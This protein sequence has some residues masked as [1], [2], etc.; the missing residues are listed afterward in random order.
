MNGRSVSFLFLYATIYRFHVQ[1]RLTQTNDLQSGDNKLT[2]HFRSVIPGGGDVFVFSAFG[3][4]SDNEHMSRSNNDN[5]SFISGYGVASARQ[6]VQSKAK[7]VPSSHYRSGWKQLCSY[8]SKPC[9]TVM[10]SLTNR[11]MQQRG[12]LRCVYDFRQNCKENISI[13]I[14]SAKEYQ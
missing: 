7:R 10:V 12:S 3:I 5:V 8:I 9:T 6:Q 14:F 1:L 13:D 4:H 11:E 2:E